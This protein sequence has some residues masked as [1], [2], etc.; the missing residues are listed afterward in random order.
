MHTRTFSIYVNQ[1]PLSLQA[2]AMFEISVHRH[3]ESRSGCTQSIDRLVIAYRLE[4]EMWRLL[5]VNRMGTQAIKLS[6]QVV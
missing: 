2:R 4:V 1:N 6:S 3:G 5:R